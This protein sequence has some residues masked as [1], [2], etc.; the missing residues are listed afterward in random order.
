MSGVMP[1]VVI[2]SVIMPNVVAPRGSA[3]VME[4][5]LQTW[6][7]RLDFDTPIISIVKY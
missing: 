3:N 4:Y 6:R 1:S 5:A 7:M 2:L